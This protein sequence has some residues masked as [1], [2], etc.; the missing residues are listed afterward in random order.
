MV[1]A[2]NDSTDACTQSPASALSALTVGASD[3]VS[4]SDSVA[5]YSNYGT[6]LVCDGSVAW[7]SLQRM[8]VEVEAAL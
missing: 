1:A 5:D 8:Q 3:F 6:C 4:N 2:G 7:T